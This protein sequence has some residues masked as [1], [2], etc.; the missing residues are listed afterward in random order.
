MLERLDCAVE[1][2]GGETK[3]RLVYDGESVLSSGLAVE[4][5]CLECGLFT[6][7]TIS[8]L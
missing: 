6:T 5:K 3:R 4:D 2:S 1:G 7:G 8:M